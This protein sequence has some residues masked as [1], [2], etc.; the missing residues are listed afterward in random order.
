MTTKNSNNNQEYKGELSEALKI[1]VSYLNG[2]GQLPRL[3]ILLLVKM[4]IDALS[5][6]YK[7]DSR[8]LIDFYELIDLSIH[9][10]PVG[11]PLWLEAIKEITKINTQTQI[12]TEL[13]KKKPLE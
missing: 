8:E 4:G 10:P 6:L 12:I 7:F 9:A 1:L 13:K 2:K 3:D 11:R 5:Y